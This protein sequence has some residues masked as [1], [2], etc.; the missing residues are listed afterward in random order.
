MRATPEGLRRLIA[1]TVVVSSVVL[2]TAS[3]GAEPASTS[4]PSP[5]STEW[6]TFQDG[7]FSVDL[8][9]WPAVAADDEETLKII[10]R[11]DWV[12][13][14]SRLE[15]IP[16]LLAHYMAIALPDFGPYQDID[17][18]DEQADGVV[19]QAFINQQPPARLQIALQYCDGSTYQITGSAPEADFDQFLLQFDEVQ[20]RS[21]CSAQPQPAL[22]TRG[23]IGMVITPSGD[24]FSYETYRDNVVEARQAGIQATHSYISWGQIERSEGTYDW[25]SADVLLDTQALEGLHISLVIEF[26]HSSVPGTVPEDLVGRSFDDPEY[27]QRAADFAAALAE[28]YGDQIAYLSLGNE[29]NIYLQSHPDDLEPYLEAFSTIRQAVHAVRPALPVGAVIAFHEVINH[30]QGTLLDAFKHGDFLAYTYYPHDA[31]FR[32]DVPTDGF[33]AILERMIQTSGELPFLVVENGFSSSPI[34]GSD[35]ERQAQYV[36]DSFEALTS[37]RADFIWHIWFSLHDLP[38]PACSD[39]ALSFFPEGFSADV[40]IAAWNA[41]EEYLCTLGFKHNSG[42]PKLAWDV[43]LEELSRYHG[44]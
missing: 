12:L 22:S 41:F 3:C 13:S 11:D 24:A 34:L 5:A 10:A 6:A 43:L 38:P 42:E 32:Y 28:R 15:T 33:N 18:D 8:P 9:D 23:L 20:R 26:I 1:I 7:S 21:F 16:R 40:D 39:L 17:V 44:R 36:R 25:S 31:G 14:I 4:S 35:E 27:L 37:H 29:V 30:D 2:A 19:I